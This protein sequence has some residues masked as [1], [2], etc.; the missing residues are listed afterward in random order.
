M[1]STKKEEEDVGETFESDGI[2]SSEERSPRYGT[3]RDTAA[4]EEEEER[5]DGDVAN[6]DVDNT[7][8]ASKNYKEKYAKA[9]KRNQKLEK[10]VERLLER[11]ETAKRRFD[12]HVSKTSSVCTQRIEGLE[13]NL[14]RAVSS[15]TETKKRLEEEQ[16]FK[17]EAERKKKEFESQRDELRD[18][19]RRERENFEKDGKLLRFACEDAT[20]ELEI[21]KQSYREE[22]QHDEQVIQGLRD[23]LDAVVAENEEKKKAISAASPAVSISA[24]PVAKKSTPQPSSSLRFLRPLHPTR[25]VNPE[26]PVRRVASPRDNFAS[27]SPTLSS[28]LRTRN[29]ATSHPSQS[30][31]SPF[32]A[33]PSTRLSAIQTLSSSSP[34]LP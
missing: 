26:S 12:E 17:E 3:K 14:Q 34:P 15:F 27:Q 20:K 7:T 4:E 25:P 24:S 30:S 29:G 13:H 5:D 23:A 11:E 10:E 8:S 6:D 2:A 1:T 9:K 22:K 16:R 19:L 28:R 33:Y 18:T 21:V 31:L 32:S